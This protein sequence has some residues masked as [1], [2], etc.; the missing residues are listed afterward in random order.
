MSA[1]GKTQ[2]DTG[3]DSI[4]MSVAS[5]S[6]AT[7]EKSSV[8]INETYVDDSGKTIEKVSDDE[9]PGVF[10]TI[11]YENVEAILKENIAAETIEIDSTEHETSVRDVEEVVETEDTKL[12]KYEF[13]GSTVQLD[14]ETLVGAVQY[15]DSMANESIFKDVVRFGEVY[16]TVDPSINAIGFTVSSNGNKGSITIGNGTQVNVT[17]IHKGNVGTNKFSTNMQMSTIQKYAGCDLS[18][19]EV[20]DGVEIDSNIERLATYI[21]GNHQ[22]AVCVYKTIDGIYIINWVGVGYGDAE[23]LMGLIDLTI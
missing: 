19:F 8:A 14:S 18:N 1:C 4:S 17:Q 22:S 5:S 9:G 15:Y 16:L 6:N 20:M 10:E 7:K 23:Q 3:N 2:S 13:N 21:Y 12:E 11:A